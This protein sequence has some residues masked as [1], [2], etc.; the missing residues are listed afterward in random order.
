M[1]S[2][3]L[4]SIFCDK[5]NGKVMKKNMCVCVCIHICITE[6]LGCTAEININLLYFN[7]IIFLNNYFPVI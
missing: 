4:Y 1:R 7:K 3:E 6:S 5:H 2:M